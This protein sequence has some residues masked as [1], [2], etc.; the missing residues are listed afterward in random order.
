MPDAATQTIADYTELLAWFTGVLALASTLQGWFIYQQIKLA[1]DEFKATTNLERPWLFI[2]RVRVQRREGPP[3]DPSLANNWYISFFW[4][5]IGRSPALIE[6]CIIKIDPEN[7]LSEVP[8]Y[9]NASPLSCQSSLAVGAE[10]ETAQIGP[11]PEKGIKNGQAVQLTI[12]GRLTYK[13]L[14]GTTHN[15]GFAM[16]VSPHLPAA[17]TNPKKGYEYYD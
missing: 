7:S 10:L 5:N 16:N 17:S 4:R 6:T 12:Y 3:I 13:E 2:E 8:D 1:R 9:A 15:T 14:N 11:S